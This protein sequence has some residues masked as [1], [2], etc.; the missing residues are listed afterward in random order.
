MSVETNKQAAL[1]RSQINQKTFENAI[2]KIYWALVANQEKLK[3]ANGIKNTAEYQLNEVKKRKRSSVAEDD[4]VYRY[5]AQ[6]SVRLAQITALNYERNK[7]LMQLKS[8][9]PELNGQDLQ[10]DNYNVDA[11]IAEV[12]SCTTQIKS[13]KEIPWDETKIDDLLR[14]LDDNQKLSKSINESHDNMDLALVGE[15]ELS[16][17]DKGFSDSYGEFG[18]DAKPAYSIGMQL[19]VPIGGAKSSTVILKNQVTQTQYLAERHELESSVKARYE[20]MVAMVDLLNNNAILQEKSAQQ[21]ELVIKET[22][23]KYNQARV[24]VDA[25]VNDQNALLNSKIDQINSRLA[26]INELLDYFNIFSDS[27]C[28]INRI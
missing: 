25:L 7:L 18:T 4:E 23:R 26:V 12:L 27:K 19:S 13:Q 16:A 22:N 10:L 15:Y 5:E 6:Y 1:V 17:N 14:S 3:V 9:L 2:R 24:S 8:L 11:T 28:S 20:Q 21:L